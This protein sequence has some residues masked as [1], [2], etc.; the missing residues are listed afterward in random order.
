MGAEADPRPSTAAV[1]GDTSRKHA[2]LTFAESVRSVLGK[3]ASFSGRAR[4]SEYWWFYLFTVLVSIATMIVDAVVGLAIDNEVGIVNTLAT[5][6]LL[7][8]TLSA[9][10]RRLHDTGRTGWWQLLPAVPLVVAIVAGVAAVVTVSFSSG[11]EGIDV[12]LIAVAVIAFVLSLVA[13]V[14]LV[15]MMCLD[16]QPGPNKYGPSPKQPVLPPSG[17]RGYLPYAGY[18]AR[19]Y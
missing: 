8:P 7:V 15:V 13:C 9:A 3:Y 17:P 6:A 16:S 14:V 11:L 10:A 2:A 18:G 5:L 1:P 12:T 19:P 4:R